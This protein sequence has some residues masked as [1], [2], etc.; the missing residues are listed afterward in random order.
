MSWA[1]LFQNGLEVYLNAPGRV[2][3]IGPETGRALREGIARFV[4]PH[5]SYRYV[6][7]RAGEP[8]A[9]LQVVSADRRRAVVAN[10]YVAPGSRRQGLASQLLQRAERD[11]EVEHAREESR[12]ADAQAWIRGRQQ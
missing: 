4:S 3:G 12:S 1:L 10:V 9:A 6:L 2:P 11:F 7:Y 5:G 8:L